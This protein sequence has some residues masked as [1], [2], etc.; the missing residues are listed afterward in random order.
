MFSTWREN[1]IP[2]SPLPLG[3]QGTKSNQ[4]GTAQSEEGEEGMVR[5]KNLIAECVG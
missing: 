1:I 4:I 3:K 2:H 5:N